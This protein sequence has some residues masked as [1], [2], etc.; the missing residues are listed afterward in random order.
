[1]PPHP[2][3]AN[4][5]AVIAPLHRPVHFSTTRTTSV[6]TSLPV[7][8]ILALFFIFCPPPTRGDVTSWHGP[9]RLGNGPHRCVHGGRSMFPQPPTPTASSPPNHTHWPHDHP[10]PHCNAWYP[11]SR[12]WGESCSHFHNVVNQ[13]VLEACM[14]IH[15]RVVV[16]W[17]VPIDGEGR[18]EN[19]RPA[20]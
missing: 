3:N 7:N 6:H 13:I 10:H 20:H 9:S 5:S 12:P 1:M 15:D 8:P 17:G 2:H 11:R 16:G 14:D 4:H 19:Q 18:V